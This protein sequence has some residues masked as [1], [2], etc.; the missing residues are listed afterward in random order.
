[1]GTSVRR[2]RLI[3]LAL[4]GR[5]RE[6]PV[7]PGP[8]CAWKSDDAAVEYALLPLLALTLRMDIAL[9][10]AR[11]DS[12]R[13]RLP[14]RSAADVGR[15]VP[16]SCCNT[17]ELPVVFPNATATAAFS[18][19][20]RALARSRPTL[21]PAMDSPSVSDVSSLSRRRKFI[22]ARCCSLARRRC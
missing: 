3:G 15:P 5:D 10:S 7:D 18:D 9:S 12:F 6:Y 8:V 20:A 1:M 17:L 16:R 2:T 22:S 21:T 14:C 4:I 11:A 19:R 13:P